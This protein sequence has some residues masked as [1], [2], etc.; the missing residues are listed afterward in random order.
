MGVCPFGNPPLCLIMFVLDFAFA[1]G[2]ININKY[3]SSLCRLPKR[4]SA[5]RHNVSPCC[6]IT[7]TQL[8]IISGSSQPVRDV[9]A[10]LV[11]RGADDG[12]SAWFI[13]VR[14]RAR[15]GE[16]RVVHP[17]RPTSTSQICLNELHARHCPAVVPFRRTLY[18]LSR[19]TTPVGCFSDNTSR[20]RNYAV[21]RPVLETFQ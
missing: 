3:S 21:L 1:F 17:S 15:R 7:V 8:V 10:R 13:N 14:R 16:P 20:P 2:E 5:G 12:G 9:S 19:K 18:T 4:P 11:V 6:V